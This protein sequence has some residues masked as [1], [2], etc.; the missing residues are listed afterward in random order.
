MFTAQESVGR[1]SRSDKM[2]Y[3]QITRLTR[4]FSKVHDEADKQRRKLFWPNCHSIC[5]GLKIHLGDDVEVADG[6]M[7]GYRSY[8]L[9]KEGQA[10]LVPHESIRHSWLML[11]DGASVDPFPPG[12]FAFSPL[13]FPPFGQFCDILPKQLYL[14]LGQGD[15]GWARTDEVWNRAT[16]IAQVLYFHEEDPDDRCSLARAVEYINTKGETPLA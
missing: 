3:S 8:V 5:R 7:M 16:R 2:I 10:T 6:L 12:V 15:T 11:P 14:P 13:L 4:F 9:K 1:I